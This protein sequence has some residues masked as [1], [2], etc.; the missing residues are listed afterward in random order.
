LLERVG[1]ADL[2]AVGTQA[3][4]ELQAAR[5]CIA[6]ASGT[7]EALDRALAALDDRFTSLTG[8]APT[9]HAGWTY[10][11]RTLV[12]EDCRRNAEI[13]LG[14]DLV[15]T[16]MPPLALVL[17][18]ARWFTY[19]TAQRYRVVFRD[20]YRELLQEAGDRPVSLPAF[21]QRALPLLFGARATLPREV[22]ADLQARWIEILDPP[23]DAPS[24]TY[25]SA[26]LTARVLSTFDAPRPGWPYAR[27]H[28]PDVMIAAA[29]EADVRRGDYLLVLGEVHAAA[30][31]L[32]WPCFLAQHPCADALRRAVDLD[33]PEV[34]LEPIVPRAAWV[35]QSARLLPALF[36]PKDFRLAL[37]EE[38]SDAP[39][40]SILPISSLIVVGA[41]DRLRVRTRD[42]RHEFDIMAVVA[43]AL[44]WRMMRAFSVLPPR[45]HSPRVSFDRFVVSRESWRLDT[46]AIRFA[47][48]EHEAERFLGARR[49]MRAHG[50]PRYVFVKVPVEPKPFYVDFAS[51]IYVTILA[52][53]IRRT[54][55]NDADRIIVVTEMLPQADQAWL[56]DAEG[57]RYSSELRMVALD[58]RA[59]S[60]WDDDGA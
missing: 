13:D 50:F 9:R 28:S 23:W 16:L 34:R 20:L 48:E 25:N 37:S 22:L 51:P 59:R 19:E 29:S 1:D 60:A 54:R 18:S 3:L 52:K 56:V 11:A 10:A 49:W 35:G 15:R 26:D 17:A 7:V 33:V 41:G 55:H 36:S 5:E 57:Q 42:G 45:P 30:N 2:R 4:R 8:R 44:I 27:Y 21:L 32:G 24:V 6:R 38:P 58:L 40:A 12:F 39:P 47:D 53:A 31:T 14:P 43:Q 46:T